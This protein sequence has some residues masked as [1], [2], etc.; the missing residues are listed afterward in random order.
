MSSAK[1]DLYNTSYSKYDVA[2]YPEIRVETYGEDFGQT[3]WV[4]TAE[5]SSIPRLLSL[6]AGS[7]VLEVGCGSGR[8]AIHVAEQ[9]G[10]EVLGVDVNAEALRNATHLAETRHPRAQ[11]R[12]QQCDVALPL[13]FA[14]A[15]FD[16]VFSNDVL[17]HL[18]GRAQV[19]RELWRVM[20]L[21]GKLLFS[22]ALVIGGMISHE[23][24]ATRSSIGYYVFSP[25]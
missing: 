3:S 24:I 17:C 9:A 10:C 18:S 16:A 6:T 21:G 15:A 13:P 4:T 14:D 19:L 8:Y 25:A 20:K 7:K 23:E 1:V 5:S 22:D 11:A 12:F 2:P